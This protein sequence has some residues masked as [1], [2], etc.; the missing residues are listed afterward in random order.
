MPTGTR[1]RGGV[2]LV[3]YKVSGRQIRGGVEPFI[4]RTSVR[5]GVLENP[6]HAETAIENQRGIGRVRTGTTAS[7]IDHSGRASDGLGRSSAIPEVG[8]ASTDDVVVTA[9][10]TNAATKAATISAH[11]TVNALP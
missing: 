11:E 2:Q 4:T 10:T 1:A 9:G 6:R 8:A 3:S 7:N 5:G